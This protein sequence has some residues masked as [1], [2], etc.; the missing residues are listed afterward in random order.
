MMWVSF[1]CLSI[2]GILFLFVV[3][4]FVFVVPLTLWFFFSCWS[5][6]KSFVFY[7]T[8]PIKGRGTW[9]GGMFF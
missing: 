6:I 8:F 1:H 9:K 5:S 3:F 4:M 2:F 7:E